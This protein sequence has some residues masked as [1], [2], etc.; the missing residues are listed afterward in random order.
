MSARLDLTNRLYEL[1][2]EVGRRLGGPPTLADLRGRSGCPPSGVYFFFEPGEDRGDGKAA[3]VVR[4][5][6]HALN[7]G[8]RSTLWGRLRGHRGPISGARAGAGDHRGSV[9][10]QHVG[11]ALASSGAARVDVEV[12]FQ[13]RNLPPGTRAAELDLE[14]QVSHHINAMPVLWL[15]VDDPPGPE[16]D[17]G[18]IERNAIALLSN[19]GKTPI[20]PP[21]P[22]WLGLSAVSPAIRESGL[23]NVSHVGDPVDANFL[24]A[25]ETWLGR[26][27]A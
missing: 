14:R 26:S 23:W 6:T 5:G 17:R 16:S 12:W 22:G 27:G 7:A 18:Y 19:Q 24:A 4:V 11:A 10:R 20:D 25:V 8:S 15:A 13:R 21:S 1:L 2:D 9:F 3:R